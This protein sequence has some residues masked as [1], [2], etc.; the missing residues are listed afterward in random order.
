[1]K[2]IWVLENIQKN[3]VFYSRLN[4]LMLL[5]SVNL[6]RRNHREDTTILYADDITIDFL[7]RLKVLEF[8][9]SIKP[10]PSSRRINK[11]VFWASSKLEVLSEIQ[12]PIIMMDHDTHI[13]KP[14][15]HLLDLNTHYVFSFE[16]GQ[17]YY[18]TS[19]DPY[20]R[21]LSYKQRWNTDSVNVSFLNLPDPS[22]TRHYANISL[23]MMEEL[24]AL[25][26]PNPQY[27]IF[28]EQL[29][30]NQL[31]NTNNLPYKSLISNYWL[32]KESTWGEVHSNGLYSIEQSGMFLKHYGPLKPLILDSTE[33]Q[34]YDREIAHLQ[35][36]INLPNLDLK[37][38]YR[39]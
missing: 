38:F 33:G 8:W 13:Y 17:G 32:C 37:A 4:I 5:A 2:V 6:W 16:K 29:L 25:K 30:L 20:I 19:V 11:S 22:F 24:T 31:L 10:I 23:Q 39:R 15:K 7:D 26:A 9:H 34:N 3:K 27:L 35:N 21:Q 28:S 18:P 36:C 1:M 12:D 14:I